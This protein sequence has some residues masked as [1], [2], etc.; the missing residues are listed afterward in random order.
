[1][2]PEGVPSRLTGHPV[3]IYQALDALVRN[4]M[5]ATEYGSVTLKVSRAGEGPE[6]WRLRFEVADTGPGI[7]FK[8]QPALTD[9]L[10]RAAGQDPR[11][12]K[13]PM[14]LAASL[15]RALGGDLGFESQ[16]GQGTRFAFTALIQ[17]GTLNTINPSMRVRRRA[18][19][20]I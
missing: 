3:A 17:P 7:P 1:M 19:M 5:R 2:F 14:P 18:F 13:E 10:V 12:V 16:P 20:V 6:G 8:D 4:A 15:A 11:T 9:V